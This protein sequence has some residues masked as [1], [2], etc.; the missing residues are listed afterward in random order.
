MGVTRFPAPPRK[1]RRMKGPEPMDITLHLGAHRTATTSFQHYLRHNADALAELGLAVWGPRRTRDGLLTG[2]IPVP[3]RRSAGEQLQRAAGRIAINLRAAEA[4]GGR[5]LLVSDENMLG[6]PR[7]NLRHGALYPDAGLRL[8][9][10]AEAFGGRVGRVALSIRAQDSYWASALGFGVA[11]GHRVPGTAERAAL[12]R[13][14]RG[15][16]DVIREIACALPEARLIVLPHETFAG[17]PVRRLAEMTGAAGLPRGQADAWLNRA[18][19]L[20]GLR[21]AVAA[22]GGDPARLGAGADED[23]WQPFDAEAVARLREAY[24]DDL[25]WLRAGA[26][27]LA[28]LIEET[29]PVE[30]GAHPPA[31]QTTRGHRNGKQER[32]MA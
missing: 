24:A 10:F 14:Q 15:W 3:G 28:T 18:P 2:V 32:R 8:A 17:R 20:G 1:G 27:G 30:A 25:F 5:R 12:A 9:R 11:R 19:T 22:R 23:R 16:R 26:D 31:G 13:A 7:P 29:G 4:Q 6:A 21:A